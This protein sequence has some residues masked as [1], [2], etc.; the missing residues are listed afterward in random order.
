MYPHLPHQPKGS[1]WKE[2]ARTK[3]LSGGDL[4]FLLTALHSFSITKTHVVQS[5]A[6]LPGVELTLKRPE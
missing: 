6:T 5:K 4:F 2:L 1:A 3:S